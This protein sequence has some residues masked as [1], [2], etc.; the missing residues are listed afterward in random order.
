MLNCLLL[1]SLSP[2]ISLLH[3]FALDTTSLIASY[4]FS[5][6]DTGIVIAE[7]NLDNFSTIMLYSRALDIKQQFD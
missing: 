6:H 7:C 2:M 4:S 1:F 5:W 3:V